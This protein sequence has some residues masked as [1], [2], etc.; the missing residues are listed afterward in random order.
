M[1]HTRAIAS[2]LG[3]WL[4]MGH[5]W[6]H[7]GTYTFRAFDPRPVS[8]LAPP[9]AALWARGPSEAT[10]RRC[11]VQYARRVSRAAGAEIGW[12]VAIEPGAL[13]GR[14]HIHALLADTE[15]VSAEL[16][17]RLWY[18]GRSMVERYDT[19]RGAAAYAAKLADSSLC[20]W[21]IGGSLVRQKRVVGEL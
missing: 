11:W 2:V 14:R 13:L 21:D 17:E 4:T 6:S 3:R 18:H 20:D 7:Y 12:F 1:K 19:R 5:H 10:A 9:R 15:G 16:A 8:R